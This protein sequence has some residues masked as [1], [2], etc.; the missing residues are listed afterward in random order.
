MEHVFL[1]LSQPYRYDIKFNMY[2]SM[3]K[4]LGGGKTGEVVGG[5]L[6]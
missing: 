6:I 5:G 1:A 2:Q 3:F 4:Q